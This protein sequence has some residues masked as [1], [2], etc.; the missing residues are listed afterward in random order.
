ML[1]NPSTKDFQGLVSGNL[2]SKCPIVRADISNARKSFGPDLASIRGK[3]VQRT[4]APVVADYVG[5]PWQLVD[6]NKA[7]TLTADVFFMDGIAFLI[8]VSRRIKFVTTKHL[9]V[10]TV[11]SLSKYLQQVLLVYEQAS[12]RVRSILMDGEF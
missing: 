11:T 5:I 12:F 10:R 3:T 4:P 9:P 7:V 1:G 8:T 2:I 6:A